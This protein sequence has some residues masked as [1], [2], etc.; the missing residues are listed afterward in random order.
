MRRDFSAARMLGIL[1]LAELLGMAVWFAASAV[2]PELRE[3]WGLSA[4][5]AAWLTTVVQ[6]GFVAGTAAAAV[7]NLADIIQSRRYFAV[8]ALAAAAANMSMLLVPSYPAALVARFFTGF[9]L[10]GVYPPALKMAATWSQ[11]SRGLAVAMV[12]GALTVGKATPYLVTVLTSLELRPVVLVTSAGAVVAAGLVGLL[13]RDGPHAFPRRAFDWALVMT[14]VRHRPTRLAT[15]GYLGHMWELYAMWTWIPAFLAASIAAGAEAGA[16]PDG[17]T[18]HLLAWAA[19]AVGGPGALW[20]GWIAS[21]WGYPRTVTVSMAVSG[22]LAILIGFLFG[23]SLWLVVPAALLWGF[24][25]V[26][27]SA[28]F[29][30]L[31]TEVAPPHA[32]G[33]ALTLQ[34]SAGF[35][36]TMATIQLIPVLVGIIGWRWAFM[37]LALGPAAGILAISRLRAPGYL[38]GIASGP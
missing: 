11:R 22:T 5:G 38:Q 32:V 15:W 33:T 17:G 8:S 2:A 19:I 10:A 25:V 3:R 18:A 27:D 29:S 13:Y 31:V 7:L 23:G 30:A 24:F 20:G 14:V 4:E 6:L 16:M 37:V 9:F 21:R 26:A 12:V 1:A 34:T 28:Q 35:L 36:L